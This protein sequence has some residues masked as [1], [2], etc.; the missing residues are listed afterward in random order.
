MTDLS[1]DRAS[2][3]NMILFARYWDSSSCKAV[4]TYLCCLH[5]IGKDGASTATAIRTVCNVL[6]LDLPGRVLGVCADGDGEMQG[7]KTGLVGQLRRDCDHVFATHCAAHR[8]VLAVRDGANAGEIMSVVDALISSVYDLFNQRPKRFQIWELYARKHGVTAVNFQL[9]NATR[10]WSRE[11]AVRQLLG[12]LGQ[13]TSHLYVVTRP[14][15]S[16][17]WHAAVAV[18]ELLKS[19]LVLVSLHFVADLLTVLKVSRNLFEGT[20][21]PITQVHV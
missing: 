12:C 18:L 15:S 10:W 7:H 4:T 13:L 20:D 11:A 6:G 14:E 1:S 21:F 17:Y 5:L 2:H 16:M 19:P 8:Q 9:Y 3:E